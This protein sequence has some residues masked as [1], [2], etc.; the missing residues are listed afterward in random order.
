M[1][2][3]TF[4]NIASVAWASVTSSRFHLLPPACAC[5]GGR[6]ARSVEMTS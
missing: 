4:T 3:F 6:G 1:S 2:G 5:E